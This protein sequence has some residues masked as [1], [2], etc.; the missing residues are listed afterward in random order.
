MNGNLLTASPR[1]AVKLSG[2]QAVY[3]AAFLL[4]FY[5]HDVDNMFTIYNLHYLVPILDLPL[6]S[7]DVRSMTRAVLN[8]SWCTWGQV[9]MWLSDNLLYAITQFQAIAKEKCLPLFIKR[10]LEGQSDLEVLLGRCMSGEDED[11]RWLQLETCMW[12]V[13]LQRDSDIYED[14]QEKDAAIDRNYD[15]NAYTAD[16]DFELIF[17]CQMRVFGVLTLGDEKAQS[18]NLH[19]NDAFRN[20]V[21]QIIGSDTEDVQQQPSL[22]FW[23]LLDERA[24]RATRNANWLR[25]TLAIEYFFYAEDQ[26]YKVSPRLYRAAALADIILEES[27]YTEGSIHVPVLY[28]LFQVDP[29]GLPREDPALLGWAAKARKRILD[30]FDNLGDLQCEVAEQRHKRGDTL[31]NGDWWRY[32][33]LELEYRFRYEMD[34]KIASYIKT[35]SLGESLP[36]PS[37]PDFTQP[38]EWLGERLNSWP[39]ALDEARKLSYPTLRGKDVDIFHGDVGETWDHPFPS[40]QEDVEQALYD[41]FDTIDIEIE[42]D[43]NFRLDRISRAEA[44]YALTT[45]DAYYQSDSN[46]TYDGLFAR[47]GL[48][49][50]DES[51]SDGEENTVSNEWDN[52]DEYEEQNNID[53]EGHVGWMNNL[54]HGLLD[55]TPIEVHRNL[56]GLDFAVMFPNDFHP[57]P[58]TDTELIEPVY[59]PPQWFHP[60]E[61]PYFEELDQVHSAKKIQSTI[62]RR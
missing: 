16:W 34:W 8:S 38:L 62:Q 36:D 18:Y 45:P 40:E 23:R 29:R 58:S 35:G 56:W 21:A 1:I 32:S 22:D 15:L 7:W 28:V 55:E 52:E 46:T 11:N 14:E 43:A 27:S 47:H 4:A 49:T 12:D 6:S 20:V 41:H 54:R 48:W 25:E 26:P 17:Q 61:K 10:F 13:R 33:A 37:A 57:M 24:L 3:R 2:T 51:E 30:F 53:A 31:N 5:S 42:W 59:G 19:Y 44:H 39:K 9:K 50:M 60:A